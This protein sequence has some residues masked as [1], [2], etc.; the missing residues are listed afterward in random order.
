MSNLVP[1]RERDRTLM[2]ATGWDADQ[3]EMIRQEIAKE[4]DDNELRYFAQRCVRMGLDPFAG[5][6]I[7]TKRY[8]KA[9]GKK[10]LVIQV[11]VAGYRAI[12][13]RTGLY[14]GQDQPYWCGPDGEWRD[15]WIDPEGRPPAAAKVAVYRKDWTAPAV[16]IATYASY[17]QLDD[18]G[19]P[20]NLWATGPDFMLAKCAEAAAL[21]RAFPDHLAAAGISVDELSAASRVSMEARRAGLDDDARHALVE[22]VTG[23]RTDSTREL[24]DDELRDVRA[25]IARLETEPAAGVV[26]VD[27]ETGEILEA[28]TTPRDTDGDDE[29]SPIALANSIRRKAEA[30]TPERRAA[31]HEWLDEVGIGRDRR[32]STY[33]TDQLYTVD[34]WFSIEEANNQPF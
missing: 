29:A 32:P 28:D 33:S 16:G 23:G 22:R 6:I 27:P 3:V 11:T 2:V 7:A 1:A 9:A 15:L 30:L 5:Q 34:Q 19:N 20:K 14:G 10:V 17:V 31:F 13:E 21:K 18:R 25:E 12:A 24:T 4:A 8:A 26:D